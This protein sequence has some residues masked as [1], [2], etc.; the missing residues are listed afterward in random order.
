M[1]N[2]AFYLTAEAMFSS[3]KQKIEILVFELIVRKANCFLKSLPLKQNNVKIDIPT[4]T[5][6]EN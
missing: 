1:S 2:S 5:K 6:S 3:F 4:F